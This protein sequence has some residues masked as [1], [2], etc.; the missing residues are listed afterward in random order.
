MSR[1]TATQSP[2]AG[3]GDLVQRRPSW[4]SPLRYWPYRAR[5]KA[6]LRSLET[7]PT[8]IAINTE[9]AGALALNLDQAYLLLSRAARR[10]LRQALVGWLVAACIF[11]LGSIAHDWISAV[12]ICG[13]SLLFYL[14]PVLYLWLLERGPRRLVALRVLLG[15]HHA[16]A[17]LE[18]RPEAWDD[19]NFRRAFLGQLED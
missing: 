10:T 16:I 18:A 3:P 13:A 19:L 2:S 6:V 7:C 14:P 15:F 4:T 11:Y 12:L 5:R 8:L 17:R 1:N 9:S